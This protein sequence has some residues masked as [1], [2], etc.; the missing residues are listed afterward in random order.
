MHI[1]THLDMDIVA[2]EGHEQVSVLLD[3]T[4]PTVAAGHR[5]PSTLVVVLDR[6]GSMAG[7]RLEG[8]KSSLA[9]LVDRLDPTDRFGLVA[10]DDTVQVVV[11]TAPLN[12]KTAVKA[13]IAA[14]DAGGS[15]DL[16]GGYLRG[17][18][19]ARRAVGPSGA[20]V[21]L[22]SDGHANAGVTDPHQVGAVAAKARQ[23]GV[24]TSALGF[25]LGYD[26]RLLGAIARGGAGN[27]LFA[28]TPDEAVGA[29]A[30][31]V[32]GLLS[33]SAQAA[34]LLVRMRPVCRGVK[35]VNELTSTMTPDGVLV[36]LGSFYSGEQRKL[37]LTFDV[38]GIPALGLAEIARLELGWVELPALVQHNVSVPIHVNVV[39]GDQAAGR[40]PNPIV[41][42][43][44]AFQQTQHAKRRA[45]DLLSSGQVA[46]ALAELRVAHDLAVRAWK[47]NPDD[48]TLQEECNVIGALLQEAQ[49]GDTSRAAKLSSA[50][51]SFKSRTRGRRTS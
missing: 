48:S 29:M 38:P 20:T 22:V 43:E 9:A 26:E 1:D 37:V 21:L 14:V 12:D 7:D 40:V 6:S 4:A 18:Q 32:E 31:E 19:E 44:L 50:D 11:P 15:T 33:Q 25:G 23:D 47:A 36:E 39:P 5:E 49:Y 8:A 27:E 28:E 2:I 41:R 46:P 13:R 24:I 17:L 34:S 10:F 51:V 16:S 35:V 45:S 3:L 30:G 42:S